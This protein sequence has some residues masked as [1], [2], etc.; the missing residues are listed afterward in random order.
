[1]KKLIFCLTILSF[2]VACEPAVNSDHL[3]SIAGMVKDLDS[4]EPLSDVYV[5]TTPN[6][7][8][9]NTDSNGNFELQ[10]IKVRSYSVYA[11]KAGYQ[12]NHVDVTTVAGDFIYVTI[13]LKK[14]DDDKK[15]TE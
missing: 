8:T 10:N 2:F 4:R 13:D 3:S 14:N 7:T 12:T 1:M 9:T 5:F 6:S 15:E 11:K